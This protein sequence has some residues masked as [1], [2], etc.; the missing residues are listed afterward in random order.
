MTKRQWGT[1][2]AGVST[3]ALVTACG[4]TGSKP[5]QAGAVTDATPTASLPSIEATTPRSDESSADAPGPAGPATTETDDQSGAITVS[6]GTARFTATLADT[7]TARAFAERLPLTLAMNDVNGNEKAFELDEALPGAAAN[8]GTIA[9][10]DLML[11]G[12]S[13][14]VLFYESFETAYRYSRIGWLDAPDGLAQA[15]GAGDVTVTF[16]GP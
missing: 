5:P 1:L 8:P 2:L 9:S 7:D 15:L 14:I 4:S 16:A 10:G 3:V 6:I 11:Y 13:T 12:S